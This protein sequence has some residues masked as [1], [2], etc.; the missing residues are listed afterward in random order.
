[1]KS[2]LNDDAN[3]AFVIVNASYA[4]SSVSNL[5]NK[6]S[7]HVL[8][9]TSAIGAWSQFGG[10]K[11]DIFIYSKGL[12]LHS[13]LPISG[14]T[15]IVLTPTGGNGYNNLKNAIQSALGD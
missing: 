8:Q 15:D 4:S 5:N 14:D 12:K 3:V 13:F 6:V 7:F 2:E 9:D 11:D 1:M 10:G